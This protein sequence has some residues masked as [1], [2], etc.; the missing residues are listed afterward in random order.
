MVAA[1]GFYFNLYFNHV[2]ISN[3]LL[4]ISDRLF[5]VHKK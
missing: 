1:G 3:L 5:K 2:F 4:N